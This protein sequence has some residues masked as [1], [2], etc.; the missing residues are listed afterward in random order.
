MVKN[1][2]QP[3][4]LSR[5]GSN[6]TESLNRI[7]AYE[8]DLLSHRGQ[9]TVHIP[10]VGGALSSAY[11][12]LRNASEYSEGD[13]L[14]QRAIRRYLKRVLSFHTQISTKNLA[15][16]LITELTQSEYIPNDHTTKKDIETIEYFINFY[17]EA[18]WKYSKI[19]RNQ[20]K[21]NNFQK[22]I[23]DVLAVRCEQTLQSHVR[24]LLF[25]HFAFS[26]LH[27]KIDTKK[28]IKKNE[29]ITNEDMS[30]IVYAAI[31]RSL[32]KSDDATIRAA[33]IDTYNEDV[34]NIDKFVDFNLKI[35]KFFETQTIVH[36]A[37]VI[38][39]NGAP[40]RFIY[41]GFFKKDAPLSLKSLRSPEILE[42]NLHRHIENEYTALNKR[43]DVGIVRSIIFL[44]ITKGIIGF[45]VEVPYD[46]LI[47]GSILWV[48]F[49]INLF[50]PAAFIAFSRL[51]LTTPVKR[52]TTAVISN[53]KIMLF[54]DDSRP[55]YIRSKKQS[56]TSWFNIVYIV[57]FLAVFLAVSY[58]LY[59]LHFNF[60]QGL[61]FFVFL[62]TASFLA[63]R[64]SRQIHELEVVN[65]PQ[66]LLS[67]VR[68]IIYLPFIYVGQQISYRY[69]RINI[70]AMILD[71]LIELPLKTILRLIRQWTLFLNQKKDELI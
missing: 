6:L 44:L 54:S 60:V 61:I 19:T 70:V 49:F 55:L 64:L 13:L 53:I 40:L 28:L 3:V 9:E 20:S 50:F 42:Q 43:L 59:S 45:A 46:I 68:D 7:D 1:M 15:D 57:S 24:Q 69:S 32:L 33:L 52:N 67:L 35:D 66:G 51:T 58:L 65:T 10:T 47:S 18:Y 48:P 23:L 38:G 36:T 62:S 2:N 34:G 29:M 39:K 12:Q 25:A 30:I 17:Y 41:S 4:H 11:E 14:Q 22:W 37:R 56:H 26:H 5:L 8:S 21:R 71:L 31:H 63:F 27:Q 16:E